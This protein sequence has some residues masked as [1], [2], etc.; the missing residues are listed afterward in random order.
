MR[1]P[2]YLH[3]ELRS[4]LHFEV[5]WQDD[6]DVNLNIYQTIKGTTDL[7]DLLQV[8]NSTIEFLDEAWTRNVEGNLVNSTT[9]DNQNLMSLNLTLTDVSLDTEGEYGTTLT[10][11]AQ[12]EI[13]FDT[14]GFRVDTFGMLFKAIYVY[15]R[16]HSSV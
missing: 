12:P 7:R 9:A 1:A 2:D 3:A 8:V 10:D 5:T 4:T 15:Y 13:T 14:V 16:S 6:R 11:A